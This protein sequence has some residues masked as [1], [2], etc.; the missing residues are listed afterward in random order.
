MNQTNQIII[1]CS[2][3]QNTKFPAEINGIEYESLTNYVHQ[4]SH[5]AFLPFSAHETSKDRASVTYGCT[6]SSI[7]CTAKLVFK[8]SQSFNS[9]FY[10]SFD[11]QNSILTHSQHLL[12]RRFIEAHRNCLTSKQIQDI[13]FQTELGVLP[14]RIR[15]NVNV[16][17]G[18]DIYYNIRRPILRYLNNES[19]DSLIEKLRNGNEKLIKISKP[20]DILNRITIVDNEILNSNYSQDVVI[21]DDTAMTNM[22]GMPLESMVVV[23]QDY[24][25]QLLAYSILPNKSSDSF[26]YFFKDFLEL[27]GFEFRII[28]VD[29]LQSQINAIEEIFPKSYIIYCLVHIR[30]DLLSHFN[31]SDEIIIG[32]DRAIANPSYSF[33]YLEYL[34]HRIIQMP[35]SDNGHKCLLSFVNEYKRWLPICLIEI[36]MFLNWDSSRIEGFFGLL[37]ANYGHDRGQ[38]TT[39]IQNLNNFGNVLKT[40]S[41]ATQ[42]STTNLYSQFPLIPT[43]Q[44]KNYGKMILNYLSKEYKCKLTCTKMNEPCVWC[45]LRKQKSELTI[46]C[47]HT[48][49]LGYIIDI[50]RISKRFLRVTS[51]P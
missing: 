43:D 28:V 40:Q 50:N 8:Q 35:F 25:T 6:F 27:G 7:G 4:I 51:D 22:Y 2:K 46:P 12:D 10:Y 24:H 15:T 37:K 5:Q 38:I 47:R 1:S 9:D 11:L 32:F 48:I 26:I 16:D 31:S 13:R 30:R 44:I 20:N 36:G 29:R 45:E 41:Y 23:D 14:G 21:I 33:T 34:K 3:I 49:Q 42:N 18:S 39:I 17:T 19:L